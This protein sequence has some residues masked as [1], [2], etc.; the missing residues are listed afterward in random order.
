MKDVEA[1][2]DGRV[3]VGQGTLYEAIHRLVESGWIRSCAAPKASST[4]PRRRYYRLTVKGRDV[5][6]AESQRLAELVE[7]AASR[8]LVRRGLSG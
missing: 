8:D 3:R 7:Y 4:D 6:R 5:L 2:R 1:R